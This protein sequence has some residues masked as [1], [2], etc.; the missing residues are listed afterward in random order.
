MLPAPHH[1]P[2]LR[3]RGRVAVAIAA[4]LTLSACAGQFSNEPLTPAQMQLKQANQQTATTVAEGAVVGAIIGGLL[5]YAIGGGRGAVI[6]AG[7]GM[8]LGAATGYAVAQ[9]NFRQARTESSLQALIQHAN[10]D[11]DAYER[12][13]NASA[14]IAADL[15]AQSAQLSAQYAA[16]AISTAQYQERLANYRNSA[17]IM[18]KQLGAM[19]KEAADLRKDAGSGG[20]D[21][22]P[23]NRAASRID[24]ARQRESAALQ[25]LNAAL[26]AVPA[27]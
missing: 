25:D 27:G 20:S 13:A 9:N 4:L 3:K 12:S 22:L 23:L 14:Q 8:A 21:V 26:S 5:G 19:E 6:G 7:S 17:D 24:A 15:R 16:H 10:A 1:P 11:A 2:R 18:T